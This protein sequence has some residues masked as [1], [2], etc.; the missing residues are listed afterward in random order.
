MTKLLRTPVTFVWLLL[1][2]ATV[3]SLWAAVDHGIDEV[4]LMTSVV[5]TIAVVKAYLVGAY[6]M[7]LRHAPRMLHGVFVAWC[8]ACWGAVLGVY[9]L[10]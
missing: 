6:F 7:E 1:V 8:V 9:F 4:A 10:G 5:I 2:A 3:T